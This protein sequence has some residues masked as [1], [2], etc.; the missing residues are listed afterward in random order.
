[1]ECRPVSSR[2]INIRLKAVPFNIKIF[3]AYAPTTS[4]EEDRE[5]FYIRLQEVI[6]GVYKKDILMAQGDWNAK[7]GEDA[8]AHWQSNCGPSSNP[9][10]SDRGLWLLE[11]AAINNLEFINLQEDGRGTAQETNI[12]RLIQSGGNVT[13][14]RRFP[15]AD[16]GSDHNVL[17][18]ISKP[19]FNL[20]KLKDPAIKE[21]FQA[22]IGG[23]LAA[24][25]ILDVRNIELDPIVNTLNTAVIETADGLLG[26]HQRPKKPRVTDEILDLCDGH[27]ELKKRKGDPEGAQLYREANNKGNEKIKKAKET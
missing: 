14:T 18:K 26:K 25:I 1:M 5:D 23:R 22:R 16:I 12:T 8:Q 3:Q 10:T 2:L 27:R 13:W 11:F 15:G 6:D 24:L 17:K 20:D 4:Y 19:R 9:L 7:V 21:E